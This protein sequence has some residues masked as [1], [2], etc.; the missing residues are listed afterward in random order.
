MQNRKIILTG[1]SGF[2]GAKLLERLLAIG[3]EVFAIKRPNSD[4]T[5]CGK[6]TWLT[7]DELKMRSAELDTVDAIIHL[8][9]EYGRNVQDGLSP[10]LA[11]NVLLPLQLMELAA[12]VGI[13][14]FISTDSFFGKYEKT[15]NY[16]KSY[17]ISKRQLNE[18]AEIFC[19]ENELSFFNMRLEHVYGE[20]DGENKFIPFIIRSL[21]QNDHA[22]KCTTGLQKRDFVY[23]DDVVDAYIAVIKCEA[24]RKYTEFEVGTG[25]SS[26]L[27]EIIEEIKR[28]LPSNTSI[29]YGAI[30]LR[31]DEIMDSKANISA[32]MDIGWTATYDLRRG[33]EKMLGS[34]KR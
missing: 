14:K 16:M 9:T 29:D 25:V 34:I 17:I 13:K 3:Y 6:V 22:I 23:I 7:Y 32:L 4:R 28:Q 15:Y 8:A 30:P 33:V 18:L 2:I 1:A 21:Q 26:P 11:C 24:K 10:V 12:V 27:K 19:A 31:H 5:T 20:G